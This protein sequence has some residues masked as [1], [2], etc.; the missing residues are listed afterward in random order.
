MSLSMA[1][2]QYLTRHHRGD[3][4]TVQVMEPVSLTSHARET[5]H[6]V[7]AVCEC[8]IK[9]L[10]TVLACFLCH[11][12]FPRCCNSVIVQGMLRVYVYVCLCLCV[13]VYSFRCELFSAVPLDYVALKSKC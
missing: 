10:S 6:Y 2:K 13:C 8:E 1:T 3:V 4:V 7:R 9:Q 11:V 12:S 5:L